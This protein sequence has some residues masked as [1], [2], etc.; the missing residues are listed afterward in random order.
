MPE[1]QCYAVDASFTYRQFFLLKGK[2]IEMSMNTITE[3]VNMVR[4]EPI[5]TTNNRAVYR[6]T[7]NRITMFDSYMTDLDILVINSV[8]SLYNFFSHHS[9]NECMC[10]DT[11]VLI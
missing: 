8:V 10:T 3:S 2:D 1:R 4:K 5:Q 9:S 11:F 7:I 6:E